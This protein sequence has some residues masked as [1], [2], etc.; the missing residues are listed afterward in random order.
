[1]PDRRRVTRIVY[2]VFIV[3]VAAFVVSSTA[4]VAIAVFGTS[5][6]GG[7]SASVGPACADGLKELVAGIDFAMVDAL[8]IDHTDDAR[9]RYVVA[10][11]AKWSR[12]AAIDEACVNEPNGKDALAAVARYDRAAEASVVRHVSELSPVRIQAQSFISGHQR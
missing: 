12:R 10:R 4:Q 5:S 1:V 6:T 8:S 9:H 2:G 3:G 11:D 7:T